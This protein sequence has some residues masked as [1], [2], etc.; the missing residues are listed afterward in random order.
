MLAVDI[1]LLLILAGF[2]FHGLFFGL[3]K[4]LGSILGVVAGV[5]A[6]IYF[7]LPVFNKVSDLFFGRDALG[8]IIMFILIFIIINRLTG[9]LFSILD[10]VLDFMSIIPFLLTINR[11]AGAAL[12]FIEGGLSLGLLL[13]A[14]M[15]YL[16][17][18]DFLDKQI[19]KSQFAPRLIDFAGK[20]ISYI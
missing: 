8:K 20:I 12:G 11:L 10:R 13:I 7:Y 4:T 6:A 15:T 3:I 9:L 1:I 16:P 5:W 14:I 17:Y 18:F 2:V 19:A